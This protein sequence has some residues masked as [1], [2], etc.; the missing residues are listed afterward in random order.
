MAF[1]ENVKRLRE[2]K[3]LTQKQLANLVGITQPTIA[4]Y[5]IGIK[6]PTIVI[7][8]KIAKELDTTCKDLLSDRKQ[9]ENTNE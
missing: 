3:G 4:Q 1:A 2:E 6:V 8:A 9:E 7:G 5:E